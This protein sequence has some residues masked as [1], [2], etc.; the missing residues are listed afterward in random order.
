MHE[1]VNHRSSERGK[2][3]VAC[4][5]TRQVD[6]HL[7]A[8]RLT[9]AQHVPIH[10]LVERLGL[11]EAETV[12]IGEVEDDR[13]AP[14]PVAGDVRTEQFVHDLIHRLEPVGETR[15]VDRGQVRVDEEMVRL[16]RRHLKTALAQDLRAVG[17]HLGERGVALARPHGRPGLGGPVACF[18]CTGV[19]AVLLG[20]PTEFVAARLL[21]QGLGSD[22]LDSR[23]G[24]VIET[25]RPSK[26]PLGPGLA[27]GYREQETAEVNPLTC[28]TLFHYCDVQSPDVARHEFRP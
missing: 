9:D 19:K 5:V 6:E 13:L 12:R 27:V 26:R 16:Q 14:E 22:S 3:R 20:G 23:R 2:E 8:D 1:P 25:H 11:D 7:G 24:R 15:H 17:L 4:D 10:E 18:G 28:I 21:L